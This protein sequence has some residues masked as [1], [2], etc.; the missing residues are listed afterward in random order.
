MNANWLSFDNKKTLLEALSK[1]IVYIAKK[2]IIENNCFNIVLTGGQS[3]LGLY[4]ILSKSKSDFKKW[5]IYISDERYL[6]RDHQD[7]NDEAIN[8]IWLKN[9]K[10]PQKNIHFIKAEMGLNKARKEYDDKLKKVAIFDLVL[11]SVGEDGHIASLF[12]GH[13]YNKKQNAIIEKNSPKFP[14]ERIS[15]S[16]K[17]LN[18]TKNLFKVIIGKSKKYIIKRLLEDDNLPAN[19]VNGEKQKVFV[20]ENLISKKMKN[21]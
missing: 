19:L 6:P 16:Y 12:P 5:H 10:I 3:I 14:S 15:I 8:H 18:S 7:R 11:L 9:N 21:I 13:K 20:I 4:K 2:S 17:K 1:E